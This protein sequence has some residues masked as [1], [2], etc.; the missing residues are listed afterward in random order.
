MSHYIII[1]QY[2]CL[3]GFPGGSGGIESA[4]NAGDSGSIPGSRTFPGEGNG[5]PLQYPY[6]ENSM[7]KGTWWATIH[8]VTNSWTQLSV[9]EKKIIYY[10]IHYAVP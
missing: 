5:N 10:Y 2:Y 3:L 6:L 8:E 1:A 9:R 7:G 4:C